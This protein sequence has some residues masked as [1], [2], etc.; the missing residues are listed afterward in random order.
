MTFEEKAE[1]I[2]LT[3]RASLTQLRADEVVRLKH[4]TVLNQ[5]DNV[6]TTSKWDIERL[7]KMRNGEDDR[8]H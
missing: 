3:N 7:K 8:I 6:D 4:L 2:M 1:Y 5:L